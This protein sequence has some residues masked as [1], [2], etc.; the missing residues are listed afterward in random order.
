MR[1]MAR[2][3]KERRVMIK[4]YWYCSKCHKNKKR[5]P[6]ENVKRDRSGQ[7]KCSVCGTRLE[8]VSEGYKL[9]DLL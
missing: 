5:V 8:L 9:G 6:K 7:L 1:S 2:T 3:Q 4:Y